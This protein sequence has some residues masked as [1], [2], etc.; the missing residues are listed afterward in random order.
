MRHNIR[1]TEGEITNDTRHSG[2]SGRECSEG[3]SIGRIGIEDDAHG[4]RLGGCIGL[5]CQMLLILS[6]DMDNNHCQNQ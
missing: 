5:L 1:E 2:V 6:P 3:A 4:S